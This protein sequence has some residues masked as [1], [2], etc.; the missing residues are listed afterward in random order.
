MQKRVV[1]ILII[2]GALAHILAAA[3]LTPGRISHWVDMYPVRSAVAW[4]LWNAVLVLVGG[5]IAVW[6]EVRRSRR[7]P[8]T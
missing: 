5:M 4:L 6:Y 3:T 7:T 8:P 2:V 1:T